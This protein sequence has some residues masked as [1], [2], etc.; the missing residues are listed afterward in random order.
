MRP[1]ST[2]YASYYGGYV[3]L[4]PEEDVLAA[5]EKQSSETQKM[6]AAIDETRGA[7]RYEDGKWSVKEVLGHVIDAERIFGYRALAIARGDTNSLPGFDEKRY[8]EHA[9]FD[10]WRV[11]DLA[12]EYALL[13]RANIVML[14]NLPAE[15]W[16][17][18]GIAN[19]GE[20]TTRALAFIM[21][22]HERHHLNV[23]RERYLVKPGS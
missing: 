22:G 17:R 1:A 15:A 5:I 12:E 21:L 2:D 13:R 4:V 14:R 3:E 10:A 18:R 6:L 20:V 9:G 23:L 19:N 7:Y 11:G 16:D 8:M